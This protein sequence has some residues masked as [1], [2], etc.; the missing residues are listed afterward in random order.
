[1]LICAAQ[2]ALP[3][4]SMFPFYLFFSFIPRVQRCQASCPRSV[5]REIMMAAALVTVFL[6]NLYFTPFRE[7]TCATE[8]VCL[9]Q[10]VAALLITAGA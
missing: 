5:P 1:M 8:V 7:T 2:A 3:V 4:S 9:S 10:A 6:C